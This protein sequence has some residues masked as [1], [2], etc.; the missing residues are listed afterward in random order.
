MGG[1]TFND[2]ENAV[3][4]VSEVDLFKVITMETELPGVSRLNIDIMDKDLIG[5][6]CFACFRFCI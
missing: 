5:E 1:R 6:Y 4:D 3:N 2:R